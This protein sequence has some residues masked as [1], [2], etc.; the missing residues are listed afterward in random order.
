MNPGEDEDDVLV[1]RTMAGDREAFGEL[2]ARHQ[3]AV[4]NLALRMSGSHAEAQDA[5]Q[6]AFVTAFRRLRQYQAG[7]SFR[8]WM[9]AICANRT[10][11]R[12]RGAFRRRRAEEAHLEVSG[13]EA[14]G[15][16]APARW[17]E[18]EA[19]LQALPERDRVPLV[20]RHMEDLPYEDVA[21]VLRI[22]V[23]AAKMRVQRARAR[24]LDLLHAP[25]AKGG[26]T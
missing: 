9:L 20:L 3:D 10:R 24:L 12:F 4:Y 19:A 22:G 25:G 1:A 21:A 14:S 16:A 8:N 15:S 18:V 11:N 23:S 26:G 17:P 2:V 5:A 6:E 13:L 7:R